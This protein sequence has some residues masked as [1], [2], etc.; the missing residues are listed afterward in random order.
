LARKAPPDP[1]LTV[2][3]VCA[4]LH[5]TPEEWQ[6]WRAEGHTPRHIVTD[7]TARVR[8]TDLNAWM[9]A[10]P[11]VSLF[12]EIDPDERESGTDD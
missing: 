12:D 9:D 1:W 2:P 11:K 8:R 5:I 3:Q 7:G 6:Q 10:L 4:E